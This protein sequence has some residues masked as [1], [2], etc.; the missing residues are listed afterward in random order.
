MAKEV[1]QWTLYVLKLQDDKWYVDVTSGEPKTQLKRHQNGI[2]A[3]WTKHY[4]PIDISNTKEL[5]DITEEEAQQYA[6]RFLR[7]YMEHYGDGNV[8][9]GDT[10]QSTST[11]QKPEYAKGASWRIILLVLLTV[12]L[13]VAVAYLLFDKFVMVPSTA[14]TITQ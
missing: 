10:N 9:G 1:K 7:K 12:I 3:P 6:G 2:G 4:K 13:A 8:R 14:L 11:K 5:G